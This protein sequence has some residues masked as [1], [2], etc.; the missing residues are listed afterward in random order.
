M[1]QVPILQA[2][3]VKNMI[4]NCYSGLVLVK[5]KNKVV[6]ELAVDLL[7]R[8]WVAVPMVL[9]ISLVAVCLLLVFY[10]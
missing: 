3:S 6:E 10:S 9:M 1:Q 8:Q 4:L 5:L 2:I 7:L